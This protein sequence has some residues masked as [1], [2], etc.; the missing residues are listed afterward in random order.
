M[1]GEEVGHDGDPLGGGDIRQSYPAAMRRPLLKDEST[2]VS[3]DGD[4]DATVRGCPLQ[5]GV[6]T[7]VAAALACFDDIVSLRTQPVR[8]PPTGTPVNEE[9]HLCATRMASSESL[10]M[11]AWAYATHARMSSGSRSG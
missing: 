9:P 8:E 6:I 10:A 2:E 7:G 5:D 1:A 4:E 3:I 11:T